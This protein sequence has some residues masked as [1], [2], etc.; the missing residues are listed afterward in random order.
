M[1][2]TDVVLTSLQITGPSA[3]YAIASAITQ[4]AKLNAT[5]VPYL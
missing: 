2:T 3:T 1:M 4:G 5:G